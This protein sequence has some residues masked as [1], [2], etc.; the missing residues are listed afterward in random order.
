MIRSPGHTMITRISSRQ[1]DSIHR[2]SGTRRSATTIISI[3]VSCDRMLI[4]DRRILA[5][6]SSTTEM[7]LQILDGV[8]SRG[9]WMGTINGTTPNG[10]AYG[11][12]PNASFPT[13]PQVPAA[14]LNRYYRY[15][16]AVD[17]RIF[18]YH[19][20]PR[21]TRV[22]PVPTQQQG[23]PAIRLNQSPALKMIVLDDTQNESDPE[24]PTSLGWGHGTLDKTRYDWLVNE[25]DTGQA[26]GKL[27]IIACHIPIGVLAASKDASWSKS[28]RSEDQ[29][30]AKLHTYPN[31]ILWI[32]GHL[33]MNTVSAFPSPD[34]SHPELGFW[35]VQ[36]SSLRDYPQQFRT[37]EIYRNSDDTVSI[38]ITDVDPAVRSGSLADKSRSY[39]VAGQEI[40]NNQLATLPTGSYNAE[41]LKQVQVSP[42]VN[43]DSGGSDSPPPSPVT[44]MVVNQ[45]VNVGGGS[46]VTRAQM[47]GTNLGKTLVVTAM[48]LGALPASIP[49]PSTTVFQNIELTT[50]TDPGRCQPDTP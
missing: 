41:L 18:Q 37:F 14:D 48:P 49:A 31:F 26:D 35:E 6:I 4:P 16:V 38:F 47:T 1:Q 25:L 17:V 24:D 20:I 7:Y 36:T 23:L 46:A 30:I 8:N 34:P 21:G 44:A 12:G 13:P 43:P 2:S 9:Y 33:H 29:I 19:N 5:W 10:T 22:Q 40:F 42:P 3:R 45:T 50:S 27:M 39:G 15:N 28:Y 11:A 32:S